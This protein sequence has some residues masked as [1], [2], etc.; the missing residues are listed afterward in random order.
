MGWKAQNISPPPPP[1]LGLHGLHLSPPRNS[2]FLPSRPIHSSM[3]GLKS[4]TPKESALPPGCLPMDPASPS[5]GIFHFVKCLPAPPGH[6][7]RWIPPV[8]EPPDLHKPP[9]G[10]SPG[11]RREGAGKA[12]SRP[13]SQ[14]PSPP[15]RGR[16]AAQHL[17]SPHHVGELL[18]GSQP[19]TQPA[20]PWNRHL[21]LG[22]TVAATCAPQNGAF[23]A[24]APVGWGWGEVRECPQGDTRSGP[25][26]L[27]GRA[28][29][30][31]H[32]RTAG[33]QSEGASSRRP[34]GLGWRPP[35]KMS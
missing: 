6:Q 7:S 16:G 30:P 27:P 9:R 20:P 23:G 21:A 3:L 26:V 13:G 34:L 25:H 15:A 14:S 35:S 24:S 12:V 19:D 17:P 8:S 5:R 22:R 32:S 28:Q 11:T 33:A 1:L 4:L 18:G 2:N 29:A 10:T 31:W